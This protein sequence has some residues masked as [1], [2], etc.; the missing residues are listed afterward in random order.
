MYVYIYPF[1][2][3]IDPTGSATT[4]WNP[5]V[6]RISVGGTVSLGF[7]LLLFFVA[8]LFFVTVGLYLDREAQP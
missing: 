7:T 3:D 5:L 6:S 8:L 4:R 2:L 1:G